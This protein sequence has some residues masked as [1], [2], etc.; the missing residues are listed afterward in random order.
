VRSARG[1]EVPVAGSAEVL[2]P[3]LAG[4]LHPMILLPLDMEDW[5]TREE[6]RGV[7]L[8]ELA[9]LER[10]DPYAILF[11][12]VL[13]SLFFFHPLVRYGLRQLSVE[14][15]LACDELV[16]SSGLARDVY[17]E[18][19]LKVAEHSAGMP[20]RYE[21]AFDSSRRVLERRMEMILNGNNRQVRGSAA[22]AAAIVRVALMFGVI[23]CLFLPPGELA[24]QL[25]EAVKQIEPA[26]PTSA[27]PIPAKPIPA[28][29]TPPQSKPVTP[30]VVLAAAIP[31]PVPPPVQEP[32]PAPVSLSGRV[33]DQTSARIP[34][35]S[36]TLISGQTRLNTLTN[37]SGTY[38]F[39]QLPAGS[40]EL[41]ARLPG[42]QT[43][44]LSN[45]RIDRASQQQ[46]VTLNVGSVATRV[47]VTAQRVQQPAA[48]PTTPPPAPP[49]PPVRIGG[50]VS[51]A[52]LIHQP[53]PQYPASMRASG[54]QGEITIQAIIAVDGS[55]LS[56]RVL[57]TDAHPDLAEAALRSVMQWRYKP[58]TL[59]GV[60]IEVVTT[61]TVGFGLTD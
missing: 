32:Q 55:I 8:H 50:D 30:S 42:F 10:R 45:L 4:I 16:T 56:P 1:F 7:I 29:A 61:I 33:Y 22:T 18:A 5:S 57:N 19:I 24:A 49:A 31:A 2:T 15:E 6:M 17:A 41:E 38:R 34:G 39:P 25:Q 58:T 51:Q 35:V 13:G 48:A 44:K 43:F 59:N 53:K 47:Q 46:D 23:T 12:A 20:Q 37:E 54:I 26:E 60:P 40:Y 21:L 11:Q 36:V 3:Q 52:N 9:H 28:V 27:E 14:R